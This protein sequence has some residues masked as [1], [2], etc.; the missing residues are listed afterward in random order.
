MEIQKTAIMQPYFFP[1]ISYFRLINAV[2]LFVFLDDVTFIKK[3]WINRNKILL[4]GK[5]HYININCK[6][7]SQNKKINEIKI[8]FNKKEI[9]KKLKTLYQA[10]KNAP[11]FNDV[12]P[13]LEESLLFETEYLSIYTSNTVM[14]TIKFLG[15]EKN[16]KYSSKDFE[17][18]LGLQGEER[19]IDICKKS[20]TE[21]YINAEGGKNLY[22]K[23][24]FD[25]ENIKLNF[26]ESQYPEYKQFDHEFISMLSIIDILVFNSKE[27]ICDFLNNFKLIQK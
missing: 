6:S 5:S 21:T 12:Y 3:G 16:F 20:K 17:N 4:N 26:L 14:Q 9:S 13:L 19:I 10:Y 23:E 22:Y 1:S 24:R 25:R 15:I 7:L 8:D 27:V 11:Y 2:D 18:T